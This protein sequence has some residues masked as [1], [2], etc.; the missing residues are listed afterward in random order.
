VAVLAIAERRQRKKVIMRRFITNAPIATILLPPVAWMLSAAPAV[1]GPPPTFTRVTISV[2]A[3]PNSVVSA[4]FNRDGAPDLAVARGPADT[5]S[6]FLGDGSGGFT[7]LIDLATGPYPLSLHVTDANHDGA[8]DLVAG[9]H[10][11]GSVTVLLGNGDG[12]FQPARE[13]VASTTWDV[14]P[15]WGY[16]GTP[17]SIDVADYNGDGH[18]DIA[19]PL[20]GRSVTNVLL[21]AGDGTFGTLIE[22][23]ATGCD[24]PQAAAAA[25]FDGDGIL[26]F[27]IA[28]DWWCQAIRLGSGD[29]RF[30][31]GVTYFASPNSR[32]VNIADLNGDTYPD[33]VFANSWDRG[34]S[35]HLGDGSGGVLPPTKHG[36][37]LRPASVTTA[38][39][40]GDGRLDILSANTGD[41]TVSVLLG[42]GTGGVASAVTIGT[43]AA[44]TGIA[45][46]DFMDNGRV[47]FAVANEADGTVSLFL[48]RSPSASLHV[49]TPNTAARWG[50]NTRQRLAWTYEGDAPQFLIEISRDSGRTWDYLRTVANAPGGS[51]NFHWTVTGPLTSAAKLR[52][53]AIGDPDATDVNDVDIRIAKATIEILSPRATS[54]AFAS[55]LMVQY[56]H[57]LGARADIAIEVSGNNGQTWRSIAATKTNGSVTGSFRWNV[58]LPPTSRARVRVRALDGSGVAATSRAFTV[59]ATT[60]GRTD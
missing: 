36:S 1:A 29:G 22:A 4:D 49:T 27:A 12:T 28:S 16:S 15:D 58:D 18:V 5:V 50:L 52:V 21:G 44:P 43:G 13:F 39:L 51:Q 37:G 47:D 55:D 2:G 23:A 30:H 38:D 41:N 48:A 32:S 8:A 60:G 7:H 24:D 59:S 31:G 26:D 9:N 11:A 35:V 42:D 56:R 57:S 40:D 14:N 3:Q 46:G 17:L 34:V 45:T 10:H 6:V 54:V 19:A 33:L 25:D 20:R 53:S